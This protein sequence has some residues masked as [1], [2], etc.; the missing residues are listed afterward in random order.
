M[1]GRNVIITGATGGVGQTVTARWLAEGA[2]VLAVGHGEESLARLREAVGPSDRLF[3]HEADAAFGP[4]AERMAAEAEARFGSPADTLVHL[5]G[6]FDM[7]P[8]DAPGAPEVW[9]RMLSLNLHS[10]FHCYRAVLPGMKR[11]RRGW[12]V[13]LGSRVAAEPG[14]QLAAYA[15]AKA[16]LTALT[17]ALAAEVKDDGVHVNLI[18]ASTIDTPANREAMGDKKAATWATGDDIADATLYLCSEKARA[19][20]GATLEVYARA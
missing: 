9:E 10:A 6:G 13:G 3:T 2:R 17:Q 14:A 8:V 5:V 19:V 15:A 18:L 12:V 1:D 20:F 16:G 4:A 11:L 7:G